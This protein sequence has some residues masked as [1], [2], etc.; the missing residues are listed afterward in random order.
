MLGYSLMNLSFTHQD[1]ERLE[2]REVAWEELPSVLKEYFGLDAL[3]ERRP[4][5]PRL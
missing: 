3:P 2:N 1:G 4:G 5:P